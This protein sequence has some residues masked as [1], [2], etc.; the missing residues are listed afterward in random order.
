MQPAHT[1]TQLQECM[2]TTASSFVYHFCS[3]AVFM[4]KAWFPASLQ[5]CIQADPAKRPTCA[6]LLNY[7][8]FKDAAHNMP[9]SIAAA[10]ASLHCQP[11]CLL[12]STHWP[13][14]PTTFA[15]C[16]VAV[17]FSFCPLLH[18]HCIQALPFAFCPLAITSCPWL[19]RHR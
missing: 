10:Q 7:P 6:E 17:S 11:C 19:C 5:A 15:L 4:H 16:L 18:A 13:A 3:F 1:R 8:F 2:S 14:C 12:P 9:E